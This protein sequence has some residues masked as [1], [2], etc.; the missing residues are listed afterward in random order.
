MNHRA[1]GEQQQTNEQITHRNKS[2]Q[3]H[4]AD[5][6]KEIETPRGERSDA[7]TMC[8]QGERQRCLVDY[9][10]PLRDKID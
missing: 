1:A 8:T 7:G 9:P 2:I 6:V 3:N 10:S 4:S 5:T